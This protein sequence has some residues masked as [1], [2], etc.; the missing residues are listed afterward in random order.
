VGVVRSKRV[1]ASSSSSSSS[2]NDDAS[3]LAFSLAQEALGQEDSRDSRWGEVDDLRERSG[4]AQRKLTSLHGGIFQQMAK[5][6]TNYK[7]RDGHADRALPQLTGDEHS[8]V[9]RALKGQPSKNQEKHRALLKHHQANYGRWLHA[10]HH[11]FGVL[12]YGVGSKKRLLV[13]FAKQQLTEH[14]VVVVNGYFPALTVRGILHTVTREVFGLAHHAFSSN[15]AHVQFLE[16]AF[17]T[18]P[19]LHVYVVVN[20]IDGKN[21]QGAEAQ[22]SLAA[23]AGLRQ[24]HMIASIDNIHAPALWSPELLAQYNW[25]WF[26]CPTYLHYEEETRYDDSIIGSQSVHER[27]RGMHHVLRAVTKTHKEILGKLAEQQ[28][29]LEETGAQDERAYHYNF[30]SA[31]GSAPSAASLEAERATRQRRLGRRKAAISYVDFQ[32]M[33]SDALLTRGRVGSNFRNILRE[34]H[35]HDLI[36]ISKDRDG[37]EVLSIPHLEQVTRALKEMDAQ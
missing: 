37:M 24:V 30:A 28:L 15:T 32:K 6:S 3:T 31:D 21:L 8:K 11:G 16:R 34:L 23:L 22:V 1:A 2:S 20:N 29:S 5:R 14:P 25:Q 13:E 33:C 7:R 36:H 17:A 18:R 35:D 12:V 26:D 19:S 27:V 10:L 9:V 4:V